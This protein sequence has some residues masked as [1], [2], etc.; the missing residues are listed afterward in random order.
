MIIEYTFLS[1]PLDLHTWWM[2]GDEDLSSDSRHHVAGAVDI[3]HSERVG[4]LNSAFFSHYAMID[5]YLFENDGRGDG[6]T[7][8][9][10][11]SWG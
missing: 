2:V 10:A 7:T 6:E 3:L 1:S 5:Q 8:E 9:H 11:T 4:L